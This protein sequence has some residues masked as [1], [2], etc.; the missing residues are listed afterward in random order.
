M[1]LLFFSQTLHSGGAE[2]VLA[3]IT[4]EL[5]RRGYNITIALN[6]NT[7]EYP[8][9][10]RINICIAP[11]IKLYQGRNVIR[12]FLRNK[13]ID[14]RD[15]IH[16]KNVI[17]NVRPDII[18]TFMHCNMFPIICSHGNIPIVHSEHNAFDRWL[19]WKYHFQRFFLNRFYDRVLVLTPFDQGYAM[20]KKLKNTVVI[21]NPNTFSAIG[22]EEYDNLFP[23]R[24]N[25]LACGRVYS[26]QIK[27][28]D[29]AIE[30]FAKVAERFPD[31]DLDIAGAGGEK[32]I[33][34][35]NSLAAKYKVENR[36]HFLGRQDDIGA[37]MRQHQLFLLSSR[38]EGFPMVVA[39]A[40]TQGLPC[41]AFERLASSIII[42]GRDGRLVK[43]GDVVA[44]SEAIAD[45]ISNDALRYTY[46]KSGL[47]NVSRF[48]AEVVATRWENRLLKPL[49]DDDKHKIH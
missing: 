18:V 20:A 45:L 29:L 40:M 33:R 34:L 8:L 22:N 15:F 14:R 1:K 35:L 47:N 28:F 31:I 7:I 48:A 19:G 39:E 23:T 46:G 17:R 2:R 12:R 11:Q 43:D 30:A 42:D 44:L 27:G 4:N 41:I 10:S 6:K 37:I 24:K 38:T 26:W 49:T 5:I 25:I 3:N 13:A 36:L 9:D 21:P 16:T 32:E